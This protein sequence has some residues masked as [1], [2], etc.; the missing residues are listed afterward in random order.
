[1]CFS[2]WGVPRGDSRLVYLRGVSISTG[3]TPKAKT[4]SVSCMIKLLMKYFLRNQNSVFIK[5]ATSQINLYQ[6]SQ[7]EANT[8]LQ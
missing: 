8:D 5:F 1:M 3:K 2:F 7:Q 4:H 6:R